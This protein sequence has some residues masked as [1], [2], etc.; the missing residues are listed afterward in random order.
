MVS[1]DRAQSIFPGQYLSGINTQRSYDDLGRMISRA[2]NGLVVTY[3]YGSSDTN[4]G[5]LT[6]ISQ[7][8]GAK[9]NYGWQAGTVSS[10]TFNNTPVIPY[11]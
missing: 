4:R 11:T 3:G 7:P 5:R 9:V 6:T 1:A 2:E 10:L 8:S